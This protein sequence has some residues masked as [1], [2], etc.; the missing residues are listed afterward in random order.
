MSKDKQLCISNY[1]YFIERADGIVGYNARKGTFALLSRTAVR[2]L[3]GDLPL[4]TLTE[5]ESLI[6]CGFLHHGDE[7]EQ[8]AAK[9][10]ST[11]TK[12][13]LFLTLTPTLSCN[14]ACEYCF[15]DHRPKQVWS[16]NTR[17]NVTNFL[18]YLLEQGPRNVRLT[19][20][21]G[22]PLLAKDIIFEDSGTICEII[23]NKGSRLIKMD[24][25]TNGILLDKTTAKTLKSV[26]V[27]EAQVS[28]D[29][30][31]FRKPDRRGAIDKDGKPSIILRNAKDALEYLE[32]YLRINVGPNL[33][34]DLDRLISFLK[35]EGFGGRYG[36]ARVDNYD[37]GHSQDIKSTKTSSCSKW[38]QTNETIPRFKYASIEN[39]A[40]KRSNNYL[41]IMK[42]KLTPKK[43]PCAAPSGNMFVIDADGYVSRCWASAGKPEEA[44]GHVS[45][46]EHFGMDIS[47]VSRWLSY[48]PLAF[49][50]CKSCKVLPLCMGGCSYPRVFRQSKETPCNSIR[51]QVDSFVT[52]LATHLSLPGRS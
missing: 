20:F 47:A 43:A 42:A 39:E 18:A 36:F 14:F 34:D 11:R 25:V 2:A 24:I 13:N 16:T 38:T 17:K 49:P 6:D 37:E 21:G 33:V 19:W 51:G 15:Q 29:A 26:G 50:E 31:E 30:L 35:E 23:N 1:N 52:E 45:E 48:T 10:H 8:V 5:L 4:E 41:N 7:I 22:E 27:A 46:F 32:V 40:F 3:Q 44:E 28:L 9:F 12:D